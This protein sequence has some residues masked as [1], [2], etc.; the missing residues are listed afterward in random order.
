MLRQEPQRPLEEVSA[1]LPFASGM[2]AITAAVLSR[3]AAGD[4]II[5]QEHL[6]S[7]TYNLLAEIAPRYGIQVIWL[8]D[9]SP[10]SW[11]QAFQKYPAAK[12]AYAETPVNP[13]MRIVDLSAVAEIA[14]QYG[15]W[16][17]V[18]NTFATPYS[19]RPLTL[20]A[21]IVMHST[22]KFLSGHGL[23]IGGIVVS[24][25]VDYVR[26]ELSN[27]LVTMGASA[28]PFDTWLANNGLKTFELRMQRHCENAL[29]IARRLEEY[30][31]ISRVY[32]PGLQSHPDHDLAHQQM[33]NFGAMM[34]FDLK[35]GYQAGVRLMENVQ[36]CSL[37]VS[38]GDVDTHIEHPASM[39]YSNVPPGERAKM[40]IGDGMVRFSVG[41]ENAED[42]LA[43]LVN[44]MEG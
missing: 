9:L 31:Q 34:S 19:Q 30:P 36:V 16:L 38:L 21:D 25:H 42:I 23:V 24:R 4:T 1:A 7:G 3:L 35:G 41:I 13:N 15:A 32:Y 40:E 43:D 33:L 22:T 29:Y 10:Q 14:H 18:D 20:G 11:E 37:A 27:Y 28:S 12:V 17:L 39:S 6:Y 8:A 26:D 44:A 5:A 2:A